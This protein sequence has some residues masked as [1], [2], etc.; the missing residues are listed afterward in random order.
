[1]GKENSRAEGRRGVDSF[2]LLSDD[3]FSALSVL[4]GV[5]TNAL[6]PRSA[7]M[8]YLRYTTRACGQGSVSAIFERRAA[9]HINEATG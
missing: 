9:R 2:S 6:R 7:E 8:R 5:L 1:M 3:S 4:G